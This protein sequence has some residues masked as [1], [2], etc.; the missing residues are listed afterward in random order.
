M[1]KVEVLPWLPFLK[2]GDSGDIAEFWITAVAILFS[3]PFHELRKVCFRRANLWILIHTEVLTDIE[4]FDMYMG[5]RDIHPFYDDTDTIS[6]ELLLVIVCDFLDGLPERRII[7]IRK[8]V[9]L[10]DLHLWHDK[11]M[12]SDGR[13]NIEKCYR[14]IIFI[15]LVAGNF[16]LDNFRKN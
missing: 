13:M 6:A 11:R 14:F 2:T 1:A 16:S 15:N 9:K 7:V 8:V 5:M 10:I 12:A 4:G 3:Q